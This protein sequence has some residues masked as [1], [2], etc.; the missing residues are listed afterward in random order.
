M[1]D[2]DLETFVADIVEAREALANRGV[3]I[4]EIVDLGGIKYASFP[5]PDVNTWTLQEI[6]T[7]G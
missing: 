7:H 3:A 4:G 2:D 5:D 1:R 6:T